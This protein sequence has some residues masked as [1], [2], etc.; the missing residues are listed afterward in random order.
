LIS[1]R[2]QTTQLFNSTK[3]TG[4]WDTYKEALTHYNKEIRKAKRSSW[5]GYWQGIEDVQGSTRLMK[6]VLKEV[7]HNVV[8]V[9]LPNGQ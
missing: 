4:E 9:R 5:R 3:R 6:I 2:L 7:T 1:L 8:S